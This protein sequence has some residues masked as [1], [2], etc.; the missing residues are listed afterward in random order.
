M[1][2]EIN[3]LEKPSNAIAQNWRK[4]ERTQV[5]LYF[6][7]SNL[8]MMNSWCTQ[9]RL[10]RNDFVNNLISGLSKTPERLSELV[11]AL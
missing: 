6:D 3:N 1:N 9:F 8:E 4:G 5:L 11:F 2:K 7:R 10:D